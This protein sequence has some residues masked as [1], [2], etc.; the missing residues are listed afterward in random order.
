MSENKRRILDIKVYFLISIGTLILAGVA[1][2][3]TPAVRVYLFEQMMLNSTY[4]RICDAL[5][6]KPLDVITEYKEVRYKPTSEVRVVAAYIKARNPRMSAEIS[7]LMAR[8]ISE[9]AERHGLPV[10][11]VVGVIEKESMFNP[12]AAAEIPAAKGEFARGLMQIYQ[13]EGVVVD[14]EQAYDLQYNLDMGCTI[15]NG[16]LRITK[17]DLAKA[18]GNYSGNTKNYAD[19]VMCNVGQ[20]SMF[21]WQKQP[22]IEVAFIGGAL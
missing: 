7:A 22:D 12:S 20:F 19:D 8:F 13:G 1:L 5:S 21:R 14:K 17:G 2:V 11:L 4:S 10:E 9:S 15:L 6:G 3:T 16:K 18:L